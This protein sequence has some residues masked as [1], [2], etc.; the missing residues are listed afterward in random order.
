MM[1][2]LFS[3][4]AA[5]VSS[6]GAR[7]GKPGCGTK[8]FFLASPGRARRWAIRPEDST[9]ESPPPLRRCNLPTEILRII[10]V[11]ACFFRAAPLG[12]AGRLLDQ[13]WQRSAPRDVAGRDCPIAFWRFSPGSGGG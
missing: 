9:A 11:P 1:G 10:F 4:Y 3:L 2:S 12:G 13:V 5:A 8:I 6:F 7:M